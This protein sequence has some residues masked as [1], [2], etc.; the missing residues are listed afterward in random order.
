MNQELE[1]PG[2]VD[3]HVH[4]RDPGFPMSETVESGLA[5]A[6]AGG[7]A[8]V[9]SMPNTLPACDSPEIME[10]QLRKAL[11]SPVS[12]FASACITKG[13]AG[14]EV[15]DI[16]SLAAAGAS[17]FTDDGSYVEDAF[18]MEEAMRRIASLGMV[19]SQHALSRDADEASAIRRDLE[20][21]RVTGCRIHVQ[22]ISTAAGVELVRNAQKEGLPVTAEATP[23]HLLFVRGD[24]PP[25]DTNYKMAPP[26]A[27][28]EDRAELRKAVKDGVLM[29]ATDHAPHPDSS[30]R[31]SWESAA[32]GIIGLE[33]AVPLTYAVMVGEEGMDVDK[34][35]QAWWKMPRE[36]MQ[37]PPSLDVKTRLVVGQRRKI[38]VSSF[39]SL[40]RNCPYDK[41]ES[42]CWPVP[43]GTEER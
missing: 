27:G 20:L 21:C 38:D 36:I 17:F 35:A 41:M 30:K 42:V 1:F 23:H 31:C 9:V 11:G 13:R 7:F 16:E 39:K 22:H 25:G 24:I 37:K 15:S 40:S 2:F 32:N 10:Y 12:L 14:A 26:L 6:A 8:A 3:V 18:V 29:F 5:A 34:W 33:A 4:L 43:V 28:P 19:A